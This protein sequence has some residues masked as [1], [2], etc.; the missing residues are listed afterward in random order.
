MSGIQGGFDLNTIIFSPEGRIYQ[1]EYINE[2]I[3]KKPILF[4]I[5]CKDGLMVIGQ[6]K[7]HKME[8]NE[9]GS[10]GIYSID[11]F[12]LIGGIGINGDILRLVNRA[13]VDSAKFKEI[14]SE[15][16]SG[17]VFL[18]RLR[19]L[20]HVHTMYW[21]LRPFGCI[22]VLGSVYESKFN[23]FSIFPNGESIEC[24]YTIHGKNSFILS[25]YMNDLK[26]HKYSCKNNLQK[27]CKKMK[28]ING[29]KSEDFYEIFIFS[30]ENLSFEKQISRNLD[31]ELQRF[32]R[33]FDL[34]K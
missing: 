26:L 4:G 30:R 20:V 5:K 3:K 17:K 8:R 23:L 24:N 31:L 32:M 1:L 6:Q 10:R 14:Y 15:N 25:H 27:I 19:E 18:A 33:C 28:I 2:D 9:H 11:R 29:I 12:N 21:H 16:L 34:N 13:K 22:L 7:K